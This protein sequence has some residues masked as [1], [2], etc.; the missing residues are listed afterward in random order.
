[1]IRR[2]IEASF[3]PER[4]V[5]KEAAL[6]KQIDALKRQIKGAENHEKRRELRENLVE[7]M[8]RHPDFLKRE[9]KSSM[10]GSRDISEFSEV[11]KKTIG[12]TA[13]ALA[14]AG[15]SLYTGGYTGVMDESSKHFF[16][17]RKKKR[18]AKESKTGVLP[19]VWALIFEEGILPE[20]V[21]TEWALKRRQP[22]KES[23][24]K[25]LSKEVDIVIAMKGSTGTAAELY[26]ALEDDWPERKKRRFIVAFGI[27]HAVSI[28]KVFSRS[29]RKEM[30]KDVFYIDY[31]D[32]E[33]RPPEELKGDLAK[34]FEIFYKEIYVPDRVSDEEREFLEKY[35][36]A[37]RLENEPELKERIVKKYEEQLDSLT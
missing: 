19:K 28:A 32:L 3:S 29:K 12:L 17:R 35:N 21:P 23:R 26:S 16:E 5:E 15:I 37:N 22:D 30:E 27:E 33:D 24:L 6:E 8:K 25:A 34:M 2:N 14:E 7:L 18:E 9:I 13:E 4:E 20:A 11:E 36:F 10:I 31:N 1:M